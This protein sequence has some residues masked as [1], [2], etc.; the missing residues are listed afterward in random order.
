M[1]PRHGSGDSPSPLGVGGKEE[2]GGGRGSGG[3]RGR[4]NVSGGQS[5]LLSLCGN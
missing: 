1:G 3:L 5:C 2:R 4:R